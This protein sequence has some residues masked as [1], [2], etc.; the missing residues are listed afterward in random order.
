MIPIAASLVVLAFSQQMIPYGW[1]EYCGKEATAQCKLSKPVTVEDVFFVNLSVNA[2]MKPKQEI[3]GEI[4]RWQVFPE[5]RLGDC[6]DYALSKR[7]VLL[8]YGMKPEGMTIVLG[9]VQLASG[10]ERHVVLEVNVA[11]QVLVLDNLS[12]DKLY[13]PNKPPRPWK[14]M[15]RQSGAGA[16]WRPK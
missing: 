6:E 9:E 5:D 11:G 7:A 13:P 14:E 3:P 8:A 15:A 4:E 2:G 16:M 1:L 10:W 12:F